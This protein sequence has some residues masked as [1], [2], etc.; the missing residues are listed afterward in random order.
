MTF[1]VAFVGL[2]HRKGHAART[3]LSQRITSCH[4]TVLSDVLF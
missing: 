4:A 3:R 2:I 1:A